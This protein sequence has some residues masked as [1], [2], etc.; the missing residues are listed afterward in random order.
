[1]ELL[2]GNVF[3]LPVAVQRVHGSARGAARLAAAILM[4][5]FLPLRLGPHVLCR[6]ATAT[7]RWFAG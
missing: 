3:A 7:A 6:T 1:M 2:E 4:L 5:L